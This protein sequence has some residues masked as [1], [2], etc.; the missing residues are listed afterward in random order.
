MS[1]SVR[2][3]GYF[4]KAKSIPEQKNWETLL[5]TILQVFC[6][7]PLPPPLHYLHFFMLTGVNFEHMKKL[8]YEQSCGT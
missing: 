8:T 2:T 4:F 5:Y 7:S 1:N 3:R 6:T